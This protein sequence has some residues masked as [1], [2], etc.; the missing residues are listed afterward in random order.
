MFL[1]IWLCRIFRV[2]GFFFFSVS[3]PNN[4]TEP[5]NIK[6][7]HLSHSSNG[8]RKRSENNYISFS[9][10]S[11]IVLPNI[12]EITSSSFETSAVEDTTETISLQVKFYVKLPD[13]AS[14]APYRETNYVVP[15][16]TLT[17]IVEQD[18]KVIEAVV[19]DSVS[20]SLTVKAVDGWLVSGSILVVISAILVSVMLLAGIIAVV[21]KYK[22]K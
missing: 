1:G 22:Q 20:P 7:S 21:Y 15:R 18:E 6:F 8:R 2:S 13:A 3:L 11:I 10:P 9:E 12:T 19:R 5:N 14:R 17:R 16:A 4:Y